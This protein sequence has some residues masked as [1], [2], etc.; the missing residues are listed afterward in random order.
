MDK[1]SANP[2]QFREDP[3][4][5]FRIMSEFVEGFEVMGSL[6][7]A[8]SIFGSAR[9][10]ESNRYYKLAREM[11]QLLAQSG[12]A[13]ITGGGPGIM[14]AANRGADEAGGKSVGLNIALPQEQ[15]SNPYA[16]VRLDFHYFFARKVMFVKYACAFVCFPGGFGTMDEFFEAM[17]LIQTEKVE[18]FPVVLIGKTYW[19]SLIRWIRNYMLGKHDYISAGD[20]DRFLVTDSPA[21]AMKLI[22]EHRDVDRLK[23][24]IP[25]THPRRPTGEGTVVGTP[26]RRTRGVRG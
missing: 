15:T 14:E 7:P 4:R 10:P 6:G 17:T 13:V 24:P 25:A 9:T 8:V 5:I 18:P 26:P 12:L 16:N 11:G 3:W 22:Q 1:M 23:L 19:S 20:M 21:K 2:D